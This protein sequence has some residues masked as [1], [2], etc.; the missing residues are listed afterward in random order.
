MEKRIVCTVCPLGC[1]LSVDTETFSVDG[2]ACYRGEIYGKEEVR[3]P[4][5]VIT[6]TV[7]IKNSLNSRCPVKTSEAIP[8]NLN[9]KVMEE[10]KKIELASPVKRGDI[11]IRNIFDTGADLIVTKDM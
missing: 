2:N 3:S 6:S 11:I 5:R 1:H 4:K 9:F 10:L 7:K 8:K